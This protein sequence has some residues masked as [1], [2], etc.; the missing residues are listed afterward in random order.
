MLSGADIRSR[1]RCS[2]TSCKY[3]YLTVKTQTVVTTYHRPT[4]DQLSRR[5]ATDFISDVIKTP[6]DRRNWRS[7]RRRAVRRLITCLFLTTSLVHRRCCPFC[8]RGRRDDGRIDDEASAVRQ[9]QLLASAMSTDGLQ[10]VTGPVWCI[11]YF[12]SSAWRWSY[13]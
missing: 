1:P 5:G 9:L 7:I 3:I 4:Y 13:Q 6:R 12:I 8:S 2:R 11:L 10:P